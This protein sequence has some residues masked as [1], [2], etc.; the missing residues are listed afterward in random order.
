MPSSAEQLY[1]Q[2]MRRYTTAMRN[3]KPD[4]IPIRPFVAEFTASYAGLTCQ[5]VTHDYHSAFLAARKC[6]AEF[7]SHYWPTVKPI[8]EELWRGGHQTLCYA[9]G[10]WSAHLASFAELP[11]KSIV[12]HVDRGDVL[13]VH[14]ALGGRFCL[15][16]G[17]PNALLSHGTADDVRACAKRVIDGVARDGG[18]IMDA[19]AIMQNATRAENLRALTEFTREYGV[20]SS[21]CSGM[22]GTVPASPGKHAPL[23]NA[24][25]EPG[26]CVPWAIKRGELPE[27]TGDADLVERVWR[28][29]D[30][31]GNTFIWQMLLS[32]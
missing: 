23:G 12:Y 1:A 24:Q 5:D 6:A 27:I 15:S 25:P 17:I 31:L 32:F 4:M 10:D 2:R 19:S 18:Y 7:E 26:V 3:D 13:R 9:E 29:V 30:G 28:Q 21:S 16:G 20:Y 8:I 22:A 14:E 11:E